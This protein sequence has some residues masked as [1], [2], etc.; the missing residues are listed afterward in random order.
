MSKLDD[1]PSNTDNSGKHF[2]ISKAEMAKTA[3]RPCKNNEHEW[4]EDPTEVGPTWQGQVCTK[5]QFGRL[6]KKG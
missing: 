2:Q 1:I 4:V 5:C 3:R 6:A